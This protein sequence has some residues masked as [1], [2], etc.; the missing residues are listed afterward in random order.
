MF[1][2]FKE[3]EKYYHE[4]INLLAIR[5]AYA[6][7]SLES[8]DADLSLPDTALPIMNFK[9]A[10]LHI[11]E[12]QDCDTKIYPHMIQKINSIINQGTF[13]SEGYRKVEVLSGLDFIPP[14]PREIPNKIMCLLDNY[15][16]VW[17]DLPPF[18]REAKFAINFIRIQ[19]FEDGNKRTA[20][21]LVN[22]NLCSVH[23]A[24]IIVDKTHIAE[25]L[26][27]IEEYDEQSLTIL[28]EKLSKRE[29][30]FMVQLYQQ[31]YFKEEPNT[32][33]ETEKNFSL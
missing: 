13:L 33:L 20:S 6:N 11:F 21:I 3:K 28:F 31:L 1:I 32:N 18:E 15:Y 12:N 5:T 30:D 8:K 2:E 14:S 10:L 7:I 17:T 25:Y 24:P 23:A 16:H 22:Y 29:L 19:P 4:Y 9:N 26:R 27:C